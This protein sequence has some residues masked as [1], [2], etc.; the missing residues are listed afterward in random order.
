VNLCKATSKIFTP[1]RK[2][3]G[4]LLLLVNIS[5]EEDMKP[6]LKIMLSIMLA[7]L[8]GFGLFL[9]LHS[10]PAAASSGLNQA[11]VID[12]GLAY[13]K[14]QQEPGG[15]ITG[16]SGTAD[17][18]AT[19]RS[20]MA[21]VAAG[22]P[23]TEMVSLAGNSM[24][25][26]LSTQAIT[27][28]HDLTGTLFPGR[29][30]ELLVAISLA[31]ED[32]ATFGGQDLVQ[33]L[34]ASYQPDTG[35]YSTTAQ[36]DYSSGAASD[37]NQAWAILGLSLAEKTIPAEAAQYLVV[38]QAADGSWGAG[39]PDTTALAVTALLASRHASVQDEAIQKAIGFF[40]ATQATSAGWKPS[41]DT[42]PLNADSTGWVIQA[43]VSAG[44]DLR[45]QSWSTNGTNPVDALL[46][47]QKPDGAIGGTYAN[48]YSTAEAIIGISGIPLT[49]L[50]RAQ[51]ANQAG[52]AVF[53]E[54]NL[55][56]TACI[57]F[58]QASYTGLDLLQ[59]SGMPVITA[60]NPTQGTAVCKIGDVGDAANRCFGSMPDYWSYWVLGSNG[61]EYS[62]IGAGQSQVMGGGV[63]A[64]TW[65][66]GN[67]PPL[68]T[69][70]N[71]CEGVAFTLPTSTAA[72]QPTTPALEPGLPATTTPAPL[73]PVPTATPSAANPGSGNFLLYT[74]VVL[75]LALIVIYIIRSRKG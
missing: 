27:F 41:W 8:S 61:W 58:T 42:D 40:H 2:R 72:S 19:A 64:W 68:L 62:A 54:G 60:T 12:A 26:Y 17:P 14:S 3:Q 4:F 7:A 24:V 56:F 71:L 1:V 6:P 48:A 34:E 18:D 31:G 51:A 5:L 9:C 28:T 35:A 38:S 20:V 23:I 66:P 25:D 30:G 70:Q 49:D 43:L 10:I 47:F 46:G 29:A 53:S 69:Y 22:K 32:P 16:F 36:Q 13:I 11:Q 55:M 37:L 67:P 21:F 63:Y 57:S 65:G 50:L 33:S 15:G 75:A 73:A 59:G 45:G 74:S 52:L 39:D 44:E